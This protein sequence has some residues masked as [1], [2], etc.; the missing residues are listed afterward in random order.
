MK[1]YVREH[2]QF[3][4]CGLNCCLCPQFHSEGVSRCPGCGGSEFHL[5]HP[6]CSVINCNK[7]HDNAEFCFQ[8]SAYPCEKYTAPNVSDSF[9][10]YRNVLKDF[11]EVKDNG[12]DSYID[13]LSKK[14]NILEYLIQNYNDGRKKSYYCLAV[15]LLGLS[16]LQVI[17]SDIENNIARMDISQKEKIMRIT[18][19]IEAQAKEEQIVLK[20][21][22]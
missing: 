19:L 10:T 13:N 8:C 15:N 1:E 16:G 6:S 4:L 12:I 9:I 5:K 14:Q 21:R 17:V 7:R 11:N 18:A 22:K 20:L 2:P 3:S